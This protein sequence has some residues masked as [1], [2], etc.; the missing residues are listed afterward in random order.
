MIIPIAASSAINFVELVHQANGEFEERFVQR[1]L[2]LVASL[3]S[4]AVII[5][6]DGNHLWRVL[7]N[8]Y[9]NICK[10]AAENSRVYINMSTD[11]KNNIATL[12]A[13]NVSSR[14][15]NISPDE[16]TE[17][18]VR[19]DVSRSTEGSGLGLS[20]AKSLTELQGGSFKLDIDG[21][22]FKIAISFNIKN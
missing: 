4:K 13:K 15:L 3:P 19:G 8:I 10:Y 20:I 11:K 9:S 21:D 6:A 12:I 5:M 18:F 16:L 1:N 7:E 17:R 14:P 2:S 22:L